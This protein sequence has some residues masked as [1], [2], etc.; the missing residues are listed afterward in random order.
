MHLVPWPDEV[1]ALNK[2]LASGL[3]PQLEKQLQDLAG[4]DNFVERFATICAYC[5][6]HLDG[7][8]SSDDMLTIIR[9][10]VLKRLEQLREAPPAITVQ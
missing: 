6:I 8:Y 2:E 4:E 1:I 7:M 9:E 10:F 5:E 3:H